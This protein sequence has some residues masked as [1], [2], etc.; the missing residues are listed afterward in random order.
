MKRWKSQL[1]FY[2]IAS[3]LLLASGCDRSWMDLSAG[4][5]SVSRGEAM[6]IAEQY[7]NHEW[8]VGPKNLFRGRDGDG[9]AV[10]TPNW[11]V[12]QV[13][14]GVAY[15]WGGFASIEEFDA[16]LAAGKFAGDVDFSKPDESR[17]AVGV[18]CSGFVSRCW[19]LPVKHST[20]SLPG[21]CI[22][23]RDAADLRPGD[24]LDY[25][26]AHVVLFKEYADPARSKIR[27]YEAKGNRVIVSELDL[28]AMLREGFT[29]YRYKRI[30]D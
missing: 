22:R 12:G 3:V 10:R 9:I 18:D 27:C 14:H 26:D 1:G 6:A 19:K 15:Q 4:Y 7:A 13:N 24:I 2:A 11:T 23:L 25:F 16:G 30:T 8:T 29:P 20:R 5:P 28:T 21:I 17:F